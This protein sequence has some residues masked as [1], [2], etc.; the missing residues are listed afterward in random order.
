MIENTVLIV[1]DE[2]II[3]ES[4]TQYL[5][6][7]GF[8]VIGVENLNSARKVLSE[9]IVDLILLD[10]KLPDGMG[11]ELLDDIA[12]L[13]E[14]PIVIVMTAYGTV[15]TAVSAMK[16]GVYDF[17]QKPFRTKDIELIIKLALET[18]KLDKELR[19]LVKTQAEKYGISSIIG[20]SKKMEEIFR[21]IKKVAISGAN[22]VLILGESGTGKELIARALHYESKRAIWPFVAI[23]C[24]AI[25]SNLLE[26]ELYGHEK[27]AFTDAKDRKIGLFEKAHKGTLFLDEIGDM[28]YDLQ[29]KLLRTLEERKIRR[30]G[31]TN[32]ISV[33]IQLI[34]ATNQDL[35][36]LVEDGK[37]RKDLYY[38]LKVIEINVPPLRERREDIIPLAKYFINYYNKK[39]GK[40]FLGLDKLAEEAL[41]NYSYPGNVRELK[42]LIE[43]IMILE[44]DKY[45]KLEHLSQELKQLDF[46]ENKSEDLRDIYEEGLEEYIK[47][48]EKRF[49][50]EALERCQGNKS[51]TAKLLKIDRS[52]LRYKIKLYGIE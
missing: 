51:E 52:T 48:L 11:L 17:I 9:K 24:S 16:K 38:R 37:F 30:I 20:K 5:T 12:S 14:K 50:K 31:G 2:E 3:L 43:K 28:S 15:D 39:L 6:E 26:S 13:E 44:D 45:I 47:K 22:S 4:L 23:N 27:G 7:R 46:K 40:H 42:N 49:I 29:T 25:P 8:N 41:I 36:K 32:D 10:I 21:I 1:D 34:A 33:D 18:R 35:I 19:L